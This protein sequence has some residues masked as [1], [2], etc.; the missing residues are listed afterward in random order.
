M[1]KRLAAIV[2]S[3]ALVF[4]VTACGDKSAPKDAVDA[5]IK[6]V[7]T[8]AKESMKD[9]KSGDASELGEMMGMSEEDM[10]MLESLD[11]EAVESMKGLFEKISDFDYELL[12]ENIDG[13]T[14]TVKVKITTYNIG[15]KL[16]EG[17]S[18]AISNAMAYAFS[19][20]S[21][22]EI[23][24]KLIAE[25]L[26]PIKDAEKNYTKEVEVKVNKVDGEWE[27]EKDNEALSN[28]LSGG[29]MESLESMSNSLMGM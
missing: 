22:E 27:V 17:M 24:K 4:T 26:V 13:E 18:K 6:E 25:M 5:H 9:I 15:D 28:A 7:K 10:K 1:I 21:E 12:D 23:T 29:V 19:G 8:E 16:S 14:A 2:M 20:M 11:G 3:L